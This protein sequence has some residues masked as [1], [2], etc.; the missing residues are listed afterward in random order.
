MIKSFQKLVLVAALA[1]ISALS[2]AGCSVKASGGDGDPGAQPGGLAAEPFGHKI[3][4]PVVEGLW[5]S[6]CLFDSYKT[7]YKL[8]S[9]QFTGQSIKR[10]ASLYNDA[11]CTEVFKKVES[12]GNFRWVS[13]TSYGGFLMDY[14]LDAGNGGTVITGEEL[15]I[16]G[17]TMYLSD[18]HMGFGSIDKNYPMRKAGTT[19]GSEPSPKPKPAPPTPE[20]EKCADFRGVFFQ[21]GYFTSIDQR[22][23][24]ELIWQ[25][26]YSD[27]TPKGSAEVY[28]MDGKPHSSSNGQQ[29]TSYYKDRGF[30]LN[31]R[32]SGNEISLEFKIVPANSTT[33]GVYTVNKPSLLR[34]GKINGVESSSY[35]RTWE[36]VK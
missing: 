1:G 8:Q 9:I 24:N 32:E 27:M 30:Y 29:M 19:A 23:C 26:L 11:K 21:N 15:L 14:R 5:A 20:P 17:D 28:L 12:V 3:E 13:Q 25:P 22:E 16:E 6:E 10:D 7:K 33:C 4:G 35:C 31:F 18:Y 36:K 34:N 2:I